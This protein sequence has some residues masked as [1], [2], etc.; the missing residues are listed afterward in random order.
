MIPLLVW[1]ERKASAFMQDRTGP[2]RAAILGIR[3]GGIIHTIADVVKLVFK[4]DITPA[5]VQPLLLHP[6]PRRWR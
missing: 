3:L 4:E 1:F 6:G 2:N 5:Q